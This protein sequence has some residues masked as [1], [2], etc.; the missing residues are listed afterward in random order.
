MRIATTI[1][2]QMISQIA[3][4]EIA[5]GTVLPSER[6]LSM[7]F[8]TSRPTVRAALQ[9]MQTRGYVLLEPARRPRASKPTLNGVFDLAGSHLRALLGNTETGVYLDQIRQFIEVGAVRM[10]AQDASNLQIAT[11]R[12]TLEQCYQAL[13]ASVEFARADAAFHRAIVT[14]V[15][16]PIILE[17]HDRFV[18]DIVVSREIVGN[19][20]ELNSASY[21]DHR[22][23]YEAIVANDAGSAMTLMDGHLSRAYRA[24][25]ER[26]QKL[27]V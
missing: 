15:Q 10:A 26:P 19:Q 22:Q 23:I 16:N 7:R 20:L 24:R 18:Y 17:M 4:G 12:S 9:L 3:D 27:S 21:E 2:D 1:A 8:E 6:E 14:V 13:N 5:V 25:L 11:I